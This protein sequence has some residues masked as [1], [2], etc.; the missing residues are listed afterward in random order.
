MQLEFNTFNFIIFTLI[1][2]FTIFL[3]TKHAKTFFG[4][5]LLD[6]DFMKP[7]AFHEEPIARIGGFAIFLL[8]ILFIAFY[9]LI[10]EAN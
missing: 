5:S 6:K 1:S 7:Q 3:I 10:Y 9:F 2:F 8:F 4:G